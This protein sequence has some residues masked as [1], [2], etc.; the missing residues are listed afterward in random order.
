MLSWLDSR[1][2]I[3]ILNRTAC[4]PATATLMATTTTPLMVPI[5][6]ASTTRLISCAR[7]KARNRRGASR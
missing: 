1:S 4:S 6:A 5:S 3:E 7:T 2:R